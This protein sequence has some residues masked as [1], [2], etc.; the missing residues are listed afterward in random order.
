[1]KIRNNCKL[2]L[3]LVSI[4]ISAAVVFGQSVNVI[5][6]TGVRS[7]ERPAGCGDQWDT[8]FTTN[9]ADDQ[10]NAIVPDGT[11]GFYIGGEFDSVQG[12]PAVGIARWNGSSWTALGSG[13]N[14]QI[15]AIAVSGND[16]YVGGDFTVAV[17][18]GMARNVAKWDGGSWSKIGASFQISG[19]V[20]E[21]P[22]ALAFHGG[23]LF[24]GGRFDGVNGIAANNIAMWDGNA[25]G[26][27]GS[28]TNEWVFTLLASSEEIGRAAC[29]GRV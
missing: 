20:G 11:G 6:P 1:M 21:T 13:I 4:F 15:N 8:T 27:V 9:G 18:G 7:T 28:G 2:F 12:S 25:W 26:P 10:V 23:R 29:R 5:E 17:T 24:A 22:Y 14:G 19:S 16:V 3:A